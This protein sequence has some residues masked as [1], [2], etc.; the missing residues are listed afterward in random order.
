[1]KK[2]FV[3]L[4]LD[5]AAVVAAHRNLLDEFNAVLG[6]KS[7]KIKFVNLY[8]HFD[9]WHLPGLIHVIL[10]VKLAKTHVTNN[11][12]NIIRELFGDISNDYKEKKTKNLMN[13]N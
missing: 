11:N 2:A 6:K 9:Y 13:K 7:P 10:N 5:K 3:A 1:M 12:N 8:V 4:L